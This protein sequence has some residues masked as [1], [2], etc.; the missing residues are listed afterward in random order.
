MG[1]VLKLSKTEGWRKDENNRFGDV[2]T[3]DFCN[4]DDGKVLFSYAPKIDDEQ[5]FDYVFRVLG[6]YDA[7]LVELKGG[8]KK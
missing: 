2:L 8:N 5:F 7:Y 3:I 6:K 1:V 4:S